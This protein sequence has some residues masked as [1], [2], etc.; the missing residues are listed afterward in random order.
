MDGKICNTELFV[1]IDTIFIELVTTTDHESN[2][3]WEWQPHK[4]LFESIPSVFD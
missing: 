2:C 4:V 3:G 1:Y